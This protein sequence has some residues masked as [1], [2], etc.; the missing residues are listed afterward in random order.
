MPADSD[1]VDAEM[2]KIL[3]QHF[4]IGALAA[5]LSISASVSKSEAR[6][7]SMSDNWAAEELGTSDQP[8]CVI[9]NFP[10]AGQSF[11]LVSEQAGG[12]LEF[13]LGS[14]LPRGV[15]DFEVALQFD[16]HPAMRERAEGIA[17]VS[18]AFEIP[19][20]YRGLGGIEGAIRS[21][22]TVRVS[23]PGSRGRGEIASFSLA[24]IGPALR[25]YLDCKERHSQM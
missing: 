12:Q 15:R 10:V 25:A 5:V 2:G 4:L 9:Y 6:V 14:S 18:G 20:N 11:R 1:G 23:L 22:S 17:N 19:L 13:R 16:R 3:V 7:L 21:A 24:G 8:L